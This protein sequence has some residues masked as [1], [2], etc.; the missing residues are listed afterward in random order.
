MMTCMLAM[1]L[2]SDGVQ[3]VSKLVLKN[4]SKNHFNLA[5][6]IFHHKQRTSIK[7]SHTSFQGDMGKTNTAKRTGIQ[8]EDHLKTSAQWKALPKKEHPQVPGPQ[9]IGSRYCANPGKLSYDASPT[10]WG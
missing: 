5:S 7:M 10:A 9:C 1:L 3:E 4:I 2:H 6:I 8:V